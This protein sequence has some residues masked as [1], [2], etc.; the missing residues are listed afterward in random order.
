MKSSLNMNKSYTEDY[1][2]SYLY[3]SLGTL[4]LSLSFCFLS[5]SAFANDD[6]ESNAYAQLSSS[7]TQV[8]NH[9]DIVQF[10]NVDAA[11]GLIPHHNNVVIENKGTYLLTAVGQIGIK[12]IAPTGDVSLWL[13]RNGH[14]IPNTQKIQSVTQNQKL[15]VVLGLQTI[16]N[17]NVGDSISIGF[18]ASQALLGL[19]ATP[20]STGIPASPSI[21]FSI[22][23]IN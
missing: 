7:L 23:Q 16:V 14:P 12:G 18:S 5:S 2:K 20:A 6:D 3:S 1:M 11:S 13:I 10:E 17:L 21:M 9:L 4:I 8:P 15:S 22:Q 19:I